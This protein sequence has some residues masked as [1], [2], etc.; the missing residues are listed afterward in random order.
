MYTRCLQFLLEL[1]PL[2]RRI[3]LLK[4]NTSYAMLPLSSCASI[5]V[6]GASNFLFWSSSDSSGVISGVRKSYGGVFLVLPLR[7][8]LFPWVQFLIDALIPHF[9]I[10]W[11]QAKKISFRYEIRWSV[12][13]NCTTPSS[14]AFQRQII[15]SNTV[16]DVVTDALS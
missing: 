15:L 9:C 2:S 16:A 11:V 4:R 6:F 12:L 7:H 3:S 14:I 8:T 10:L 1:S 5:Q 13:E